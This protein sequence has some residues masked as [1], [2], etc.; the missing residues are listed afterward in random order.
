MMARGGFSVSGD[1]LRVWIEQ[2][3]I[4]I[5]AVASHGDPVELSV[6]EAQRLAQGLLDL[7]S[8]IVASEGSP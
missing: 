7:I 1:E 2:E 8:R 3:S 5:R 6:D 4:H